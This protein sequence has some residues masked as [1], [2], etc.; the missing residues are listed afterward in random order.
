MN[1]NKEIHIPGDTFCNNQ[2]HTGLLAGKVYY[3][4]HRFKLPLSTVY[5]WFESPQQCTNQQKLLR[6][7]LC[8]SYQGILN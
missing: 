7:C 1:I 5:Y 3:I 2:Y 8:C 6:Y 4:P